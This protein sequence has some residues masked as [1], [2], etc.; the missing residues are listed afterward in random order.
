MGFDIMRD[1]VEAFGGRDDIIAEPGCGTTVSGRVIIVGTGL[2]VR[3]PRGT[4]S[5]QGA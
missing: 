5:R 2:D 3:S 4:G 1:R